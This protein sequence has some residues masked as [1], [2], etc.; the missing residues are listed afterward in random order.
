[1]NDLTEQWQK[2]ELPY[3]DYYLDI[4]SDTIIDYWVCNHWNWTE[5]DSRIKAVLCEVPTYDEYQ[6][7][8]SDQLAK[9]EGVEINDELEEENAQLKELLNETKT[10]ISSALNFLACSDRI[11]ETECNEQLAFDVLRKALEELEK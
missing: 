6:A 9:N 10:A 5:Y 1:M 7:L 4:G 2:G 3:G 11:S 8:L